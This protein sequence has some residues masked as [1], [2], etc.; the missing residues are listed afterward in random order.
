MGD[1]SMSSRSIHRLGRAQ[2][3][4]P[5]GLYEGYSHGSRGGIL[6]ENGEEDASDEG[7]GKFRGAMNEEVSVDGKS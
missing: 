5:L 2:R 7:E 6:G 1:L 4:E 3:V